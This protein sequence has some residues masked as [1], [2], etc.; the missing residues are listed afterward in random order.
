MNINTIATYAGWG[1]LAIF[2]IIIFVIGF[3]LYKDRDTSKAKKESKP[4]KKEA[5]ENKKAEKA[6]IKEHAAHE[7][8]A[9]KRAKKDLS[10]ESNGLL[11]TEKVKP[12]SFSVEGVHSAEEI[13]SSLTDLNGARTTNPF[14]DK[15][16]DTFKPVTNPAPTAPSLPTPPSAPQQR[17]FAPSTPN[18]NFGLPTAPTRPA[19][20]GV[21]PPSDSKVT[22]P[23]QVKGSLPPKLFT[24]KDSRQ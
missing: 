12:S 13:T 5:K 21:T 8:V 11:A 3:L 6:F 18:P 22:G 10:L 9:A 17:P 14:R 2:I 4:D 1:I 20:L 19:G 16:D 24:H 23:P 7:G 15:A